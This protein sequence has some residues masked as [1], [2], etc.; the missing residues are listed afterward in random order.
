MKLTS[1]EC[2]VEK[3]WWWAEKMPEKCRV[4]KQNKIGIISAS[5]WLFKKKSITMH[6]NMNVK[7]IPAFLCY[8]NK[9][10]TLKDSHKIKMELIFMGHNTNA[11]FLKV[12]CQPFWSSIWVPWVTKH[13]QIRYLFSSE[14]LATASRGGTNMTLL[15]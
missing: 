14:L 4:L 1:A 15:T 13:M 11:V 10:H 3:S 8:Q 12:S 7:F 9:V 5:G 6:G 2:I